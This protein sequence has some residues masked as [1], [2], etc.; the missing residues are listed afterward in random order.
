MH[1]Y[2]TVVLYVSLSTHDGDIKILKVK[3]QKHYFGAG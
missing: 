3:N 1:I 2:M